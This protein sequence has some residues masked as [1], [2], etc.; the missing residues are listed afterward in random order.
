MSK[1]KIIDNDSSD[2]VGQDELTVLKER[3]T[4]MGIKF[5]PSIGLDKLREVVNKFMTDDVVI[6][7]KKDEDEEVTEPEAV[8]IDEANETVEQRRFRK[9]KEANALVRIQ[10]TCMNPAKKEW[11]GEIFTA[12]NSLVGSFTKYVPFNTEDGWHVPHIIYEQ[13]KERQCQVFTTKKSRN[14]INVRESKL[15]REFGVLVLPALTKKE[16]E[17]L[18]RQQA[19]ANNEE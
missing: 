19:M 2:K 10:V 7:T 18:A 4:T 11:E 17:S 6:A 14:G 5:H 3:A 9:K 13:I 12:G 15:I 8:V 1:D 16:L